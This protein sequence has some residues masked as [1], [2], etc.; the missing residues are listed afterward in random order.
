MN[1]HG[2]TQWGVIVSGIKSVAVGALW[3]VFDAWV[4]RYANA[5][6]KISYRTQEDAAVEVTYTK[7]TKVEVERN[8]DSTPALY[9]SADQDYT[10]TL[11]IG[12]IPHHLLGSPIIP[13]P[14]KVA[15]LIR[16]MERFQTHL[17]SALMAESSQ[18]D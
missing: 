16:I 10:A 15:G 9:R 4:N 7:L 13:K 2:G 8:I 1:V 18:E 6:I 5:S 17:M 14:E 3:R 11:R 12:S